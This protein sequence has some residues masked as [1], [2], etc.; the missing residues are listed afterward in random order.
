M[1]HAMTSHKQIWV[2]TWILK[3]MLHC[4]FIKS[5]VEVNA[6]VRFKRMVASIT[7]KAS[8]IYGS[9]TNCEH[10]LNSCWLSRSTR[11][12]KQFFTYLLRINLLITMSSQDLIYVDSTPFLRYFLCTTKFE[13]YGRGGEFFTFDGLQSMWVIDRALLN[14]S[15]RFPQTFV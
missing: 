10:I 9:Q 7:P 12:H 5:L 6:K 4:V 3:C 14:F 11:K 13:R 15:F 1:T 8:D 2:Q